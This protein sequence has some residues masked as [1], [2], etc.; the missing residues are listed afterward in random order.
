MENRINIQPTTVLREWFGWFGVLA[1]MFSMFNGYEN[2]ENGYS[3]GNIFWFVI[4]FQLV[5][6]VSVVF[7]SLRFGRDPNKLGK[8]AFYS[9][10]VAIA[11][12]AIFTFLPQ[13]LGSVLFAISPAFL[14][15]AI[16]RRAYGIMCASDPKHMVFTYVSGVAAGFGVMIAYI[17]SDL[18][19]G[20]V[21]AEISYF[22]FAFFAFLA[23]F[24]INRRI[25]APGSAQGGTGSV[26]P[27]SVWARMIIIVLVA[28]WLRK[29]ND[30][31][32]F[33]V[34]QYDDFLFIPVYVILPPLAYIL[35]GFLGD[36]GRERN[37]MTGLLLVFLIAI[38][39]AFLG[40]HADNFMAVPLVVINH[41]IGVYLIYFL[42]T[43]SMPFLENAKRP[44]FAASLGIAIYITS[45]TFNIFI[46]KILPDSIKTEGTEL[47]VS[48]SVSAIVF[49]LL[50]YYI[51]QGHRE[52]TLAAALHAFLLESAGIKAANGNGTVPSNRT[53][54]NEEIIETLFT[55]EEREI[56]LLL[57][58]GKS[59][60][61]ITRKMHLTAVQANQL[62]DAIQDKISRMG[63]SDLVTA[64]IVKDFGLTR[65][66]ADMLRALRRNMTNAEIAEELV[67]SEGTVKIHIRNLM[68]KIPEKNRRNIAEWIEEYKG[69]QAKIQL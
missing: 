19:Y 11:I 56:S 8:L 42:I 20:F 67:L 32:D 64:S 41:F 57:L 38:Q 65:R 10:P 54:P 12:T 47:Y 50:L 14:A 55:P 36:K 9:A 13:P 15:P 45:R 17:N 43:V 24:G 46:G 18:P 25:M 53:L 4:A 52:K 59:R 69:K 40:T 44:V 39:L 22:I 2:I 7:V 63:G 33:A 28:V 16:A 29:M 66:E 6:A 68:G 31:V 37:S 26:I 48:I 35:L 60:S 49:L 23:W 62:M 58:E 1:W 5:F 3:E 21:P 30:L 34:E 61:E 27:S 51:Y